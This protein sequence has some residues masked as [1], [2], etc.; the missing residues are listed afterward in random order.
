MRRLNF[1][2]PGFGSKK[3]EAPEVPDMPATPR[4][5]STR[6]LDALKRKTTSRQVAA[7]TSSGPDT[8]S[9]LASFSRA[10][11]TLTGQ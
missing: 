3:Q 4:A 7:R 6:A 1:T 9:R 11:K 5:P 2:F 8:S 10:L